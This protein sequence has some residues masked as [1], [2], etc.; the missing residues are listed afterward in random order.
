MKWFGR[1]SGRDGAR[2]PLARGGNITSIGEWPRS[3][4]AQVREGYCHNP[5]AQRAVKLVSEGV[6]SAPLKASDPALVALARARSGG[7][8]LIETVAAQL[9]LH[10]RRSRCSISACRA[11]RS[12]RGPKRRP[13]IREPATAGSSV[14]RRPGH[15]QGT[16]GRLRAGPVRA[17]ASSSRARACSYGWAARPALRASWAANGASAR[18]MENYL[19]RENKWLAQGVMPSRNQWGGRRLM[20]RRETRLFRCWKHY[21]RTV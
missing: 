19:S 1:K 7:Q 17:G 10:G 5:V 20:P 8:A 18:P 14:R 9:L 6:G 4:E 2:L 13:A 11:P 12:P 3:Y 15:G 21:A 16:A